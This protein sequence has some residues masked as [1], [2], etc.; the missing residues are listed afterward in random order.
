VADLALPLSLIMF[1]VILA[2]LYIM[3]PQKDF[4]V[5]DKSFFKEKYKELGA[6]TLEQKRVF[7][8][9]IFLVFMWIFRKTLSVGSTF[10]D[11]VPYFPSLHLLMMEPSQYLLPYY[12]S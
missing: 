10:Q 3:F 11:G 5:L 9:F 6:I 12:F 1:A 7:V 4:E 8:L 2:V